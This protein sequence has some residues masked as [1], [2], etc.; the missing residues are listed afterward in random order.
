MT[1]TASKLDCR[2]QSRFVFA[3]QRKFEQKKREPT[4]V[5]SLFYFIESSAETLAPSEPRADPMQSAHIGVFD[6][7]IRPF[8]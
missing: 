7:R 1:S 6:Q 3:N 4:K 5:G 8:S 2:R